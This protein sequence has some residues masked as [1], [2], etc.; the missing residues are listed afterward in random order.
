MSIGIAVVKITKSFV[1]LVQGHSFYVKWL[2][3]LGQVN[4]RYWFHRSKKSMVCFQCGVE[5]VS[6]CVKFWKFWLLHT[7]NKYPFYVWAFA[8]ILLDI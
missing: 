1:C 3:R 7:F 8:A 5:R 6:I 4:Y 2:Q